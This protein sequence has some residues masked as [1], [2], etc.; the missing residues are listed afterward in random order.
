MT[1]QKDIPLA[2]S[3]KGFGVFP[4]LVP[5]CTCKQKTLESCSVCRRASQTFSHS[6]KSGR[7]VCIGS[8]SWCC[9]PPR[10]LGPVVECCRGETGH[11]L[12][13]NPPLQLLWE[14]RT[15]G[16]RQRWAGD[17]KSSGMSSSSHPVDCSA[18]GKSKE[19]STLQFTLVAPIAVF[20]LFNPE[21]S[22]R[23]KILV[24]DC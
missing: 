5:L 21:K 23:T 18:R 1:S 12:S 2:L 13:L 22:A 24:N 4:C 19:S 8:C 9:R 16:G 6:W 3:S 11:S 17:T 10:F 20:L 14:R 15:G 7:W